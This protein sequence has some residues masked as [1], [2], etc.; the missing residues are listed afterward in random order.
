MKPFRMLS[1]FAVATHLS[2]A[3]VSAAHADLAPR[4]AADAVAAAQCKVEGPARDYAVRAEEFGRHTFT[5]QADEGYRDGKGFLFGFQQEDREGMMSSPWGGYLAGGI[6]V[7][8]NEG[9]A[10]REFQEVVADWPKE[11]YGAGPVETVKDVP[12]IGAETV[13]LRRLSTWEIDKEQPMTEVFLAFRYCNVN[14]HV[15]LATMPEFD[16]VT[17]ALR[18]ASIIQARFPH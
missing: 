18:Y 10:A 5:T 7:S 3:V 8:E 1:A 13:V 11:W 6:V 16:T 15:M 2:V 12:T 14:A 4:T 9:V 17:Q